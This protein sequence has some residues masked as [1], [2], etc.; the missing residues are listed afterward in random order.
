MD[1][2]NYKQLLKDSCTQVK[3]PN[4]KD[5]TI[6][7]NCERNSCICIFLKAQPTPEWITKNI[8]VTQKRD[9]WKNKSKLLS[10]NNIKKT[11]KLD[12]LQML[13]SC[14]R[15]N[16]ICRFLQAQPVP[17]WTKSIQRNN[18]NIINKAPDYQKE[19][20]L[21]QL[22]D[23]HTDPIR[24]QEPV[25]V[26]QKCET[27]KSTRGSLS[28]QSLE[29][30]TDPSLIQ[31][32]PMTPQGYETSEFIRGSLLQQELELYTN[33]GFDQKFV[34]RKCKTRKSTGSSLPRQLITH[35]DPNCTQESPSAAHSYYTPNNKCIQPS[36]KDTNN[37]SFFPK[38][39]YAFIQSVRV[40][41]YPNPSC[42]QKTSSEV[43]KHD[44]CNNKIIQSGVEDVNNYNIFPNNTYAFIQS[45]R[46]K[47]YPK[48]MTNQL[49]CRCS[50]HS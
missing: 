41:Q 38:N 15:K 47:K 29:L 12:E 3:T 11:D 23:L 28:Q 25:S 49:Q 20:M 6:N 30:H 39:A 21:Q 37:Y 40:K 7:K 2:C 42:T 17:E 50:C 46:A 24:I 14:C 1:R 22:L 48:L 19:H 35:T 36:V 5:D 44:A 13:K 9:T 31:K 8:E 27:T 4:S 26:P 18:D 32:T 43:H 34:R 16:S 33:P 10:N 45:V